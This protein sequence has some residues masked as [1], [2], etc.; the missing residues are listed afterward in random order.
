[1][2]IFLGIDFIKVTWVDFLD[3]FLVSVLLF[4]VYNLLKGS[5]GLKIL[6][7]LIASYLFYLLVKAAQMDILTRIFGGFIEVGLILTIILFQREIKRFLLLISQGAGIQN[8]FWGRLFL[9]KT[10]PIRLNIEILIDSLEYLSKYSTGALL[11]IAHNNSLPNYVDTGERLDSLISKNLLLTIFFKNT[12]LHDGAVII[13]NDRLLAAGCVLP[14]STSLELPT[15]CG[16]RHRAAASITE[17]ERDI[18][19]IIVSEETGEVAISFHGDIHFQA[20]LRLV[21]RTLY[22][23]FNNT[24][25]VSIMLNN[26]KQRI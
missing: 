17:L 22:T 18:I 6:I 9:R 3:I 11:I 1:M 7:G 19:A 10:L 4:T 21:S 16:L 12:A 5:V 2:F 8:I 15:T 23:F 24:N 26:M 13:N 25:R 14:I 20:S